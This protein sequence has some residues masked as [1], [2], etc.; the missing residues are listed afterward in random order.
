MS[1][2]CVATISTLACAL[3]IA[4]I[5]GLCTVF[6]KFNMFVA[7]TLLAACGISI[8]FVAHL[9]T[10]FMRE[11]GTPQERTARALAITSPALLQSS[12]STVVGILPM[13]LSPFAFVVKYMFGMF[14]LVQAVG[15]L[16]G[17]VFL[18]AF[19]GS[20]AI[21]FGPKKKNEAVPVAED[22]KDMFEGAYSA[23]NP[24]VLTSGSG[25]DA[26]VDPKAV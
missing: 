8:E 9:V 2:F 21:S 24:T 23:A 22:K 7:M 5:Y 12:V 3:I 26:S 19:L 20:M 4:E 13:T 14:A 18:P 25:N 16:N 17:I 1:C 10:A 11:E 15:L 6:L